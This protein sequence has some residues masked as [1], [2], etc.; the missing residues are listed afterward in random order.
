MPPD[1]TAIIDTE[2]KGFPFDVSKFSANGNIFVSDSIGSF[3]R[4]IEAAKK[5][6]GIRFIIIDSL[7]MHTLRI[8][9]HCQK[10]YKGYE[11]WGN[12]GKYIN[13]FLTQSRSTKQFFF[14]TDTCDALNIVGEDGKESTQIR[15]STA[16]KMTEDK[17]ELHFTL[18]LFT[19]VIPRLDKDTNEYKFVTMPDGY[20]SAKVPMTLK[21]PR[22]VNNDLWPIAKKLEESS[23]SGE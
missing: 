7:Y 22:Y 18:C 20:N 4:A 17:I 8:V 23:P 15:A 9:E 21:L 13:S 14:V 10:M 19:K 12:T 2:R 1:R 11:I 6:E 5:K 16:G 3:A